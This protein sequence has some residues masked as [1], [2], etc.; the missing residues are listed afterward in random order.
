[1]AFAATGWVC[2]DHGAGASKVFFY[3]SNDLFTAIDDSDYF[4]G[5]YDQLAV[6]DVIIVSSDIDGS[7][8][9]GMLSV[10]AASSSTVTT[11]PLSTATI[12]LYEPIRKDVNVPAIGTAETV[13][14]HAGVPTGF[15]GT[16]SRVTGVSH[17]NGAGSGGTSTITI[18]VPTTGAIATLPFLQDY[19]AG[20]LIEDSSITAHTALDEDGVITIA[21]D[22]TGSHTDAAIVSLELTLSV[23]P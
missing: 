5:V 20:T 10:T 23:A 3:K 21:T 9:P 2:T 22:G 8:L 18:T 16:V 13:Y 14:V 4:L 17:T 6:G 19:T 15:I 1:M 7:P 12:T 11:T